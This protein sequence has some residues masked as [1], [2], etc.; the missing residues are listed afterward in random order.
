VKLRPSSFL[1]VLLSLAVRITILPTL[2]HPTT[3][4]RLP[5]ITILHTTRH[6]NIK[7]NC[8][9]L[10]NRHSAFRPARTLVNNLKDG[11]SHSLLPVV[12]TQE[13]LA[14]R[15]HVTELVSKSSTTHR[16]NQRSIAQHGLHD[17]IYDSPLCFPQLE[18]SSFA[19]AN[20]VGASRCRRIGLPPSPA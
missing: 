20:L 10:D 13:Y 2:P 4:L 17:I 15:C 6:P 5:T 3:K 11:P 14:T 8:P 7:S 19:I 1:L 9:A 16:A 18:P 12:N